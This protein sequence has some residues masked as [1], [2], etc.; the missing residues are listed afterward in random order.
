MKIEIEIPDQVWNEDPTYSAYFK[1]VQEEVN[2][3]AVSHY[4]YG[5]VDD[6]AKLSEVDELRS[7]LKR[8]LMY[9]TKG[10]TREQIDLIWGEDRRK[11][12][13][14]GNTEN[15]LDANNFFRLEFLFPKHPRA[16]FKA[17]TSTQSPGLTF[18]EEK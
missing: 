2:R 8:L 14:T 5:R 7:G 1:G 9:S 3:M 15:L 10:F 13:N 18:V 4:K 16:H 6:N 12:L 11:P 17:Q